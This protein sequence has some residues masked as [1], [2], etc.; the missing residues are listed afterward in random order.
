[1]IKSTAASEASD[2]VDKS[3]LYVPAKRD[4]YYDGNVAKYLLDLDEEG[5]TF[6]FCG[7]E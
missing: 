7:G 1:M 6:D 3:H 5:V 4:E 2:V